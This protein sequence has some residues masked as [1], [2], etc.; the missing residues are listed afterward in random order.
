MIADRG[1]ILLGEEMTMMRRIE[2]GRIP[3]EGVERR[4]P[5]V[6]MRWLLV[7]ESD[8]NFV[9]EEILLSLLYQWLADKGDEI[10]WSM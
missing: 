9:M 8:E 5:V 10:A 2:F 1:L 3:G 7:S 4:M 6:E